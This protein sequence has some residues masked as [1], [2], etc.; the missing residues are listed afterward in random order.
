MRKIRAF[1]KKPSLKG[2][3]KGVFFKVD[4]YKTVLKGKAF[5][6]ISGAICCLSLLFS[7]SK[8][9]KILNPEIDPRSPK[10]SS[11]IK[12]KDD[13]NFIKIRS[14][15][16]EEKLREQELQDQKDRSLKSKKIENRKRNLSETFSPIKIYSRNVIKDIPEGSIAKV[17]LRNTVLPDTMAEAVLIKNLKINGEMLIPKGTRFFGVSKEENQ[18]LVIHFKKMILPT[19]EKFKFQ[20]YS[21]RSKD[22]SYGLKS[23]V[24]G[25]RALSA[26]ASTGLYFV[27]GFSE[28]QLDRMKSGQHAPKSSFKNGVYM[29]A[30]KASLEQSRQIL[31]NLKDRQRILKVSKGRRFNLV[32]SNEENKGGLYYGW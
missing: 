24:I 14:L 4:G 25:P 31:S 9:N 2:W 3:G 18:R 28:G 21:H 22:N 27:S 26:L 15:Y 12:F 16:D 17:K 13:F 7:F 1:L 11:V 20:G 6:F 29:G 30:S 32:F 8:S 5:L 19:G 10:L 23:T